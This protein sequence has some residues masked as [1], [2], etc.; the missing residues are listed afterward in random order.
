MKTA[1]IHVNKT[2]EKP[3]G[4][5]IDI[6]QPETAFEGRVMSYLLT[7]AVLQ[8]KHDNRIPYKLPAAFHVEHRGEGTFVVLGTPA[9]APNAAPVPGGGYYQPPRPLAIVGLRMVGQAFEVIHAELNPEALKRVAEARQQ[10]T[11]GTG[12]A[13]PSEGV[14]A[15]KRD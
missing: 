12:A 6:V 4:V 7:H 13:G 8:A 2:P 11:S 1:K 9:P 14:S 10:Q 3:E 15:S 5:E